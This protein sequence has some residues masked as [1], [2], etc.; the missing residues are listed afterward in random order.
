MGACMLQSARR[1]M[2][3]QRALDTRRRAASIIRKC[4]H[5]WIVDRRAAFEA[6]S[7]A[8][9]QERV[10]AAVRVA[11]R[12]WMGFVQRRLGRIAQK[13]RA[14]LNAVKDG[15]RARR[16]A[17]IARANTAAITVQAVFRGVR[18][19]IGRSP[20]LRAIATSIAIKRNEKR[21]VATLLIQRFRRHVVD[22]R[23]MRA[24]LAAKVRYHA[25]VRM[26][27]VYRGYST[28]RRRARI[29][30][31][32]NSLKPSHASRQR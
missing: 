32:A 5:R 17:Q 18:A 1:S 12:A 11:Q 20:Y 9:E 7:R 6:V 28:R 10:N 24:V 25:A 15:K 4:I 23:S 2:V 30:P 29:S 3:A 13:R 21:A 8:I 19:R 22:L 14:H 31:H 16:T 26:Q 27:A